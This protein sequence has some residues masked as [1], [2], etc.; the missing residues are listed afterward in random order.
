MAARRII[1]ENFPEQMNAD[2]VKEFRNR[3]NERIN[4]SEDSPWTTKQSASEQCDRLM[5][6]LEGTPE[7]L[8]SLKHSIANL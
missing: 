1:F 3:I 4:E 7:E 8:T 5:E 6:S 2:Q